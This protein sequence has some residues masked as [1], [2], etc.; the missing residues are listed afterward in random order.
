MTN[1]VRQGYNKAIN[2]LNDTVAQRFTRMAGK[3][4]VFKINSELQDKN[5]AV[6]SLN[7]PKILGNTTIRNA[8][9]KVTDTDFTSAQKYNLYVNTNSMFTVN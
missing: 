4:S 5:V 6:N 9:K 2:A 1:S 3:S 8:N 7:V